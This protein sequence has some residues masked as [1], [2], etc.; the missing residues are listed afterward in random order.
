VGRPPVDPQTRCQMVAYAAF[1]LV[2][3]LCLTFSDVDIEFDFISMTSAYMSVLEGQLWAVLS[4]NWKLIGHPRLVITKVC[5]W[6]TLP[7]PII[8]PQSWN[9]GPQIWVE[10]WT[11]WTDMRGMTSLR[12]RLTGN[13]EIEQQWKV[14][15]I[16]DPRDPCKI[17]FPTTPPPLSTPPATSLAISVGLLT[18]CSNA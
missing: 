14:E 10:T 15:I 17:L 6:P 2:T 1:V 5:Q 18:F 9:I 11:K 12:N 8:I 4:T 3:S 13:R 7:T 16:V